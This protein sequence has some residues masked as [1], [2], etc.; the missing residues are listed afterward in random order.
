MIHHYDFDAGSARGD[1]GRPFQ[2]DPGII[3]YVGEARTVDTV[4]D[5]PLMRNTHADNAFARQREAAA[6]R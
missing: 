5:D 2:I 1:I 6:V 3:G 4:N